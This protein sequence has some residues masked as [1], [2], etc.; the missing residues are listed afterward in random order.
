MPGLKNGAHVVSWF[1]EIQGR[2]LVNGVMNP[3]FFW[4]MGFKRC[5]FFQAV[6]KNLLHAKQPERAYTCL[7]ITVV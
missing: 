7:R 5:N 2:R 3:N 4:V 6:W 1:V